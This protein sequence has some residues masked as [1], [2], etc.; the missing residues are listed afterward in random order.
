MKTKR[1]PIG[2][3][4]R[5]KVFERDGYTCRYCGSRPPEV[6]L[7]V[8]HFIPVKEGG[9]NEMTN[10]LTSCKQCN[11]GKKARLSRSPDE[12]VEYSTVISDKKEVI[13]QLKEITR[14]NSEIVQYLDFH[15]DELD[16]YW[17]S[18]HGYNRTLTEKGRTS[19]RNFLRYFDRSKIE[20]AMEIAV[21][22][23]NGHT[24][25]FRYMCG[26]LQNWKKGIK[27]KTN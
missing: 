1:K 12:S 13:K 8:D 26:V 7:E 23:T 17:R 24:D 22:Q 9:D 5:F 15:V 18:L 20:E 27:N 3:S 4:K 21:L 11:Q 19:I 25:E 10:L 14:L 6:V 2:A 16:S